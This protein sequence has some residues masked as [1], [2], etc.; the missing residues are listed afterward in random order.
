M[1][2][3]Y[4]FLFVF[5]LNV[6][7]I[8]A[9]T[10]S[11]Q[12]DYNWLALGKDGIYPDSA[13]NFVSGA[14]GVPYLQHVTIK[15]PFDTTAVIFG[16]LQTV[17]FSR[18]DLQTNITNPANYG[19]PPG[20]SIAGTPS[21]FKF[22]GNDTSCMVIYGT[23]TTSGTY[24]LSF[25][26]KTYVTEFPLTSVS[27]DVIDYYK[28][29]INPSVGIKETQSQTF[30]LLGMY[31]NPAFNETSV[32]YQLPKQGTV[33]HQIYNALGKCVY[34]KTTESKKGENELAI[35]VKN[36]SSGIYFYT[37]VFEGKSK[38]KKLI[39]NND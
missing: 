36:L 13:T 15:V 1:K 19:L 38:T 24:N 4:L 33:K 23:P 29:T 39:V 17:R 16:Q 30:D 31:P 14:V 6:S 37:S 5:I 8:F 10:P 2:K 22:P 26:L 12:Y 27:T 20:L 32:K 28:I 35:D 25:T 7:T 3:V 9:Q 34:T 21:N 11:C 18:I